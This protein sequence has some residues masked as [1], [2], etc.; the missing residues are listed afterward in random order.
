M[1]I[2]ILKRHTAEAMFNLLSKTLDAISSKCKHAIS[3]VST[4]SAL[5][6]TGRSSAH[7]TCVQIV[8]HSGLI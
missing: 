3:A 1:A 2:P 7:A 5:N 6:T 4:D 8:R